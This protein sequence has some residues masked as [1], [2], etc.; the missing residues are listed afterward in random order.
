MLIEKTKNEKIEY[1]E[2]YLCDDYN[3]GW[4]LIPIEKEK[5]GELIF[6]HLLFL[7]EGVRYGYP[8]LKHRSYFSW[9]SYQL[10][11]QT[12]RNTN[13]KVYKYSLTPLQP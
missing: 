3:R 1:M 10:P 13:H 9:G 7:F 6:I 5:R 4:I 11:Y 12:D 8:R 2:V